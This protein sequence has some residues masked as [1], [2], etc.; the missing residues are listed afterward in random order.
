LKKL[1]WPLI[2]IILVV[3]ALAVWGL[4]HTERPLAG[5]TYVGLV[6]G[7]RL[8]A[9]DLPL[10]PRLTL[11]LACPGQAWIQ[12]WPLPRLERAVSASIDR[13]TQQLN[14]GETVQRM[15]PRVDVP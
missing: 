11:R 4:T 8:E 14:L 1:S 6:S 12:L 5:L 13:L 3:L 9:Y 10:Q 2:T 7:C 15:I